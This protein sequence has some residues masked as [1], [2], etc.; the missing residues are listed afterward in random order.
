MIPPVG[1]F[2]DDSVKLD[3]IFRYSILIL[4]S[5]MVEFDDQE[6]VQSE[7]KEVRRKNSNFSPVSGNKSVVF[8]PST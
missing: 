8:F 4:W 6:E 7:E 3:K 1:K 2:D 5:D